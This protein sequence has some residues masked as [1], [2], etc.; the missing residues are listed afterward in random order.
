MASR[1]ASAGPVAGVALAHHPL[2]DLQDARRDPGGPARLAVVRASGSPAPSP[3]APTWRRCPAGRARTRVRRGRAPGTPRGVRGARGLGERP[4]DIDSGV[5]IGPTDG[6]SPMGLDV[7]ERRQIQLL[8]PRAVARL[9]DREQLGQAPPVARRERRGDGVEGVGERRGDLVVVQVLGA[10]LDVVAIGLEP[11]VIVGRDAVAEHVHGLG[12]ALERSGQLLGDERVGQVLDR[13]RA[14]DRVVIGDRHEVHPAALG[15]LVDLNGSVAHSGICSE[16]WT[17][18]FEICEAEEWTCRSARLCS[19]MVMRIP[20]QTRGSVKNEV[21]SCDVSV[22]AGMGSRGC[23]RTLPLC[24]LRGQFAV[25]DADTVVLRAAADCGSRSRCGRSSLTI[26]RAR[27]AAGSV[28]GCLGGRGNGPRPLHPVHRGRRGG[29]GAG[30]GSSARRWRA[31]GGSRATGWCW[32]S[33]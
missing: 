21:M 27:P 12:L 19:F 7:D 9:P 3:R 20:L 28:D 10:R 8:G 14:V 6:G 30:A 26:R 18:S 23:G 29:R 31:C 11:L 2:D 17:P 33:S 15:E 32:R 25:S 16:R 24:Q 22:T 1:S 4:A 13:Q 5:V